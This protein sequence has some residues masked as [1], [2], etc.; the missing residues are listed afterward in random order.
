MQ[1][2]IKNN[3]QS[4]TGYLG[5]L[6]LLLCLS[7]F[8]F[9]A[10]SDDNGFFALAKLSKSVEESQIKLDVLNAERLYYQHKTSMLSDESLDLDLLDEQ[11]RTLLGYAHKDEMIYNIN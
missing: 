7:Y 8:V 11:A 1:Q 3:K 5:D 2:V 10:F 4:F 9:H 6:F